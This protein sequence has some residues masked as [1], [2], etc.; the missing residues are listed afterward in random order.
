MTMT[1]T[2]SAWTA[3]DS[4][5]ADSLLIE[6]GRPLHGDV[7]VGGFKHA[8]VTVIGAAVVGRAPVTITNCPEIEETRVLG[9]L[10]RRAGGLVTRRPGSLTLTLGGLRDEPLDPALAARIH[11]AVY[12]VP[13]LLARFGRVQLPPA[14]GCRIGDRPA[15]GRPVDQYLAVLTRFGAHGQVT[16][17]G[18]LSVVADRLTGCEIDL[19]EFMADPVLLSGPLY[20]GATKTAILAAA[21]AHGTTRLHY[22]YPK[23]DVTELVRVLS[24]MGWSIW[25]PDPTQLVIEGRP[26]RGEPRP[27][28]HA[29]ISDLIEVVTWATAAVVTGGS[30]RLSG[31][32]GGALAAGLAPEITLARQMGLR[33]EPDGTDAVVVGPTPPDR[34]VNVTVASHGI[35]SDSQP[36]LTLLATL[37]PGLSHI[38]ETVWQNRFSHVPELNRLGTRIDLIGDAARI[39]GHHPPVRAAKRLSAADLRGASALLLAALRPAGMTQLTGSH[40]L[41]RGYQDLV[42]DLRRLGAR[43]SAEPTE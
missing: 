11:G 7:R 40:H 32:T 19:R 20:S 24:A 12:L 35:Y 42:G 38:R 28:K 16:A 33:W 5:I 34:P 2:A 17:D 4:L 18:A 25:R 30:I 39:T 43:I 10:L 31:L 29:L 15:G 36:F 26:D 21:A 22:P 41:A 1:T 27:V 9:E 37:A 8:L 14:G 13:G 6:G 3:T 23:P